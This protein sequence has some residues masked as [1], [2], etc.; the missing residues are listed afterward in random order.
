MTVYKGNGSFSDETINRFLSLLGSDAPAPGGGAAAGVSGAL[1]AAL[2]RMVAE[3]TRGREK[4]AAVEAD[5]IRASESLLPLIERFC[6]LAD[7]DAA[8]YD[9]YMQALSLPKKTEAQQAARKQALQ[10]AIRTA[11]DVPCKVIDTSLETAAILESL[12]G[13]SNRTCVGDLAAGAASLRAAGQTA[14]L[15]VLAN[16]PYYDDPLE[17]AER[18]DTYRTR[19]AELTSRCDALY[20]TIAQQLAD[21]RKQ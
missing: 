12:L 1:G 2:G 13:R 9:G 8:A 6:A 19:L 16:L 4:Y 5:A 15:N 20:Q 21:K 10:T 11:T 17:A 7:A 18:Y 14:W 3:L